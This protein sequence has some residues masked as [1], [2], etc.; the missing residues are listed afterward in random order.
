ARGIGHIQ[1][2]CRI[3]P[4]DVSV[5]LNVGTAHLSEFGSPEAIA[6][7]KGEIVQALDP[8]GVAVLNDDDRR[9]RAMAELGRGRVVTFGLHGDL[10]MSD[11]SLDETGHLEM[12]LG[13]RGDQQLA[14]VPLIGEHHAANVAAAAAVAVVEGAGLDTVAH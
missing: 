6:T 12:R 11:I 13:W 2:L 1:T 5:V 14:R 7:A 8:A 4:P 9:V 3:T 10:T